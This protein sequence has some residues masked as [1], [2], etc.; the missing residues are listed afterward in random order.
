[1]NNENLTIHFKVKDF[2][3]WQTKLQ[4]EREEP[5]VCRHHEKQSISQHRGPQ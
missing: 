5:H 3:T 2:N 1:M 4:W